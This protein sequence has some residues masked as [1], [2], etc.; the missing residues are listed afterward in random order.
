MLYIQD[1]E[2]SAEHGRNTICI[3][4]VGDQF[5]GLGVLFGNARQ[6]LDQPEAKKRREF[7]SA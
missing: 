5:L 1:S 4:Q 6:L 7:S 2:N 3:H